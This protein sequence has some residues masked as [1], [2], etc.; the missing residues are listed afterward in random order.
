[1]GLRIKYMDYRDNESGI[2]AARVKAEN[3]TG[4]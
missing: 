3:P 1:M 4:Y 2:W